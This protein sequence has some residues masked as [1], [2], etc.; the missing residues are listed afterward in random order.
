MGQNF[1]TESF[2]WLTAEVSERDNFVLSKIE[3][4]DSMA[5][6]YGLPLIKLL[7]KC[8][9]YGEDFRVQHALICKKVGLISKTYKDIRDLLGDLSCLAWT[10]TQKESTLRVRDTEEKS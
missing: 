7:V 8:D 10:Y 4:Q 9:G 5:L 6:R 3:I 2:C 1:K